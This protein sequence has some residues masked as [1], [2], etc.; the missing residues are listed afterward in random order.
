LIVNSQPA[1][2]EIGK[3]FRDDKR[4]YPEI[5]VRELLA[6]AIIHQDFE[7]KDWLKFSRMN[8]RNYNLEF[9]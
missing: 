2:E 8:S 3:A 5:A 4:M 6:N 9:R 7:E 1:N